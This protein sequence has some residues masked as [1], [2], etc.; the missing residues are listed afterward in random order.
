LRQSVKWR[1]S[2][3]S[4]TSPRSIGRRSLPHV[5]QSARL[6]GAVTEA[7]G[8]RATPSATPPITVPRRVFGG[9]SVPDACRCRP[10][11]PRFV[12]D[13]AERAAGVGRLNLDRLRQREH[14][15]QVLAGNRVHIG[16]RALALNSDCGGRYRRLLPFFHQRASIALQVAD[17]RLGRVHRGHHDARL[18]GGPRP[19]QATPLRSVPFGAIGL[20]RTAAPPGA[21]HLRDGLQ[22]D[23]R[24]HTGHRFTLEGVAAL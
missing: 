9:H 14:A 15:C 4:A 18:S 1:C 2:L 12:H 6:S 20:D 13:P 10:A 7:S 19:G 23:C 3:R 16:E 17:V 24:T 21:L 5:S 11:E 8:Y 22:A